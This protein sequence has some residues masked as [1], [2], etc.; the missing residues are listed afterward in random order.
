MDTL[1]VNCPAK[2]NHLRQ[3]RLHR[4][5]FRRV[6]R[7]VDGFFQNDKVDYTVG[8]SV[9]CAV[10][11]TGPDSHRDDKVDYTVECSVGWTGPDSHRDD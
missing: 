5:V 7:R 9:E 10:G 6:F 2:P 1:L 8:C 3:S 4:R 11:W